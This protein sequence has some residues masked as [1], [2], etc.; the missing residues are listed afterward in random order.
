MSQAI[1]AAAALPGEG[2]SGRVAPP[3]GQINPIGPIENF[4]VA[5]IEQLRARSGD[6]GGADL[7]LQCDARPATDLVR[8]RAPEAAKALAAIEAPLLA[9]ARALEDVLDEDAEH[10]GASE[11][12]RIEGRCAAWTAARA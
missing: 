10:L 1:Q 11:R 9:L 2:W 4:L 6:R 7:G 8:E 5:V 3:D 12:A